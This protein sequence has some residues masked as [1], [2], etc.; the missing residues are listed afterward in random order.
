MR[1]RTARAVSALTRPI[2]GAAYPCAASVTTPGHDIL[3]CLRENILR[4]QRPIKLG[5]FFY[6]KA[7]DCARC[8][9]KGDCLSNGHVN[10]AVVVGHDYPARWSEQDRRLSRRHRW[11]SEGF[12]GEAK[13][14][15][16]L[17]CAMRHGLDNMKIQASLA[18]AALN[19]KR[20][21][22][23]LGA[24]LWAIRTAEDAGQDPLCTHHGQAHRPR[25]P[26]APRPERGFL[27]SPD[28]RFLRNARDSLP[29]TADDDC[30]QELR[31]RS[32]RP[33]PQGGPAGPVGVAPALGALSA[34]DRLGRG[35]DRR[36]RRS[37]R[38][39]LVRPV[40]DTGRWGIRAL[41]GGTVGHG[42]GRSRGRWTA[43]RYRRTPRSRGSDDR[44]RDRG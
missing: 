36:H 3:K 40:S 20:L 6:L 2:G 23:A 5:R 25:P 12:H 38:R 41:W 44:P 26:R 19:L 4:P 10:K 14:W 8:Q 39:W 42:T 11:R 27:H 17:G 35:A 30:R 43:T 34:A 37:L 16:G 29:R 31:W 28:G 33:R 15:H 21:G 9:L 7:R 1:W 13:T 24:V 22:A 18:A 32:D